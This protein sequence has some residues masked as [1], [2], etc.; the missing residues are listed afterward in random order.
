MDYVW[1]WN[2]ISY[3]L[4]SRPVL[5]TSPFFLGFEK[6]IFIFLWALWPFGQ[7]AL[8][9]GLLFYWYML[10]MAVEPFRTH[11]GTHTE[12]GGVAKAFPWTCAG[13]VIF[14]L[15][16]TTGGYKWEAYQTAEHTYGAAVPRTLPP[17]PRDDQLRIKVEQRRAEPVEKVARAIWSLRDQRGWIKFGMFLAFPF[18]CLFPFTIRYFVFAL[19]YRREVRRPHLPTDIVSR[20]L[21]GDRIDHAALANALTSSTAEVA[22]DSLADKVER[23]KLVELAKRVRTDAR[24]LD[25]KFSKEAEIARLVVSHARKREEL[26]DMEKKLREMGVHKHG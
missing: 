19:R 9:C 12:V 2:D 15:F 7:I 16:G 26:A 11:V 17:R 6:P 14:V 10:A 21:A 5:Q 18:V 3:I 13:L 4:E 1:Y 23:A 22:P 8:L 20:A 25:D 24:A